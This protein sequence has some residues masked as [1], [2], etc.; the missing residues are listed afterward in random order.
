M[1]VEMKKVYYCDHCGRHRLRSVEKH[2]AV[3]T[4]NPDRECGWHPGSDKLAGTAGEMRPHIEWAKGLPEVTAAALDDLRHRADGCP[5]CMLNVVRLSGHEV[6]QWVKV[7]WNYEKEV[8]RFNKER[9]ETEDWS[10]LYV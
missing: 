9:Q 8:E 3:C 7:G 2:E 10:A 6:Y 4:K 5:A 1:K